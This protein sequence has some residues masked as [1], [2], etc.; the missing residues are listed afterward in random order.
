M[1]ALSASE[2]QKIDGEGFFD[3]FACGVATGIAIGLT[4]SPDP[5]TKVAVA[6]AWLTAI[7][8]CGNAVT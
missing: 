5:V 3:G 6:S 7:G 8:T 1:T 4:L 2:M